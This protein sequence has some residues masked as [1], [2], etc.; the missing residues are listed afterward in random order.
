[1]AQRMNVN[2]RMHPKMRIKSRRIVEQQAEKIYEYEKFQI[3]EMA[4]QNEAPIIYNSREW[5]K[6]R[7]R[8]AY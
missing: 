6:R 1:M 8:N 3:P 4:I 2:K 7:N 5:V